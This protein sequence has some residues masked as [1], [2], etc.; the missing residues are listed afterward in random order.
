MT[1]DETD[2]RAVCEAFGQAMQAMDFG[3]MDALWD[4][5]YEHFVYQP[6]EFERPCRN[7]D[8]FTSYLNYIPGVV[9]TVRWQDLESDVAVLGDAAI[10]YALVRLG[11]ELDGVEEPMEGDVR[12]TYGLRRT[13]GGWRLF[14]AHESRQ[15]ILDDAAAGN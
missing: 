4:G 6:E 7:W 5:E 10:V 14:H 2:V 3:A 12:F 11:F 9:K 15:L 1:S 8:E 13:Q